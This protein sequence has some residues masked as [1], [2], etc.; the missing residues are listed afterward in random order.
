M[1]L[2]RT[3]TR[4][5]NELLESVVPFWEK[6]CVDRKYGGYF[7]FLDRDG[8]TYDTEKF[9][10]MQWRIVYMF[11]TLYMS[12]YRNKKWL[13]IAMRGYDFL[14]NN[15]KSEDGSYYFALNRR[16][17][18][19]IAP[20]SIFSDCFAAM[21]AAAMY[22]ATGERKY[23]MEAEAA[24]RTYI[25]RMPNPKGR[26]EKSLTGKQKR[27][28]LSSYMILA[29]LGSVM[30]DCLGSEDYVS[31]TKIAVDTVMDKFWNQEYQVIFENVNPDG[32]FDLDSCNGRMI[33]PGHGLESMWFVLQYAEGRNDGKLIEKACKMISGLYKFGL[34]RKHG[35]I[36]YFMDVLGK[37]NIELQWDMKLWWPH[38]EAAIAA[39]FAYRLSGKNEFLDMFEDVDAWSWKHFRDRKHGEWYAY[40]NRSGQPTHYHKGG[41]W[42][43]FFHVPRSLLFCI[44]QMKQIQ[45]TNDKKKTNAEGHR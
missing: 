43:T 8:S 6:N 24:M 44:G 30:K 33:N 4:Y 41:K 14:V 37:P 42:K 12:E 2:N 45:E 9:M 35:G 17:R 20:Y 3:I 11:A 1:N 28:S 40:L 13:D 25:S 29:N 26:W 23:R 16:G 32:T 7:T 18:P 22:K 10:W 19:S 31:D 34:D 15:G 27:L 21:G 5:E 38:N 39:I 36:Y